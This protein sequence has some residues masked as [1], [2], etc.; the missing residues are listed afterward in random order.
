VPEKKA[1]PQIEEVIPQYLDGDMR[2]AA[3][4]FVAHLR[5]NKMPPFVAFNK[6][7]EGAL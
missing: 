1:K 7:L 3:L 2:R 6:P 4:G 5:A